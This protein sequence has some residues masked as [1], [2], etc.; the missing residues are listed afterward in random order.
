M[1][2]DYALCVMQRKSGRDKE[3]QES[4]QEPTSPYL[5]LQDICQKQVIVQKNLQKSSILR[6]FCSLASSISFVS[7][8]PFLL[9]KPLCPHETGIILEKNPSPVR[10]YRLA[11]RRLY[12]QPLSYEMRIYDTL[13]AYR[14]VYF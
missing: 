13:T 7:L 11:E 10:L 14:G 4:Q 2:Q 5:Y 9:Q 3:F 6:K 8:L 1:R 12:V